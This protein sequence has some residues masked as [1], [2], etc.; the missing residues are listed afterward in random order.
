MSA[1][2]ESALRAR[3]LRFLLRERRAA[4]ADLHETWSLPLAARVDQGDAI[5][6]VRPVARDDEGR[7]LLAGRFDTARFRAG[8]R[9]RLGEVGGEPPWN[10]PELVLVGTDPIEGTLTLEVP[11]WDGD[12]QAVEELLASRRP[13]RLDRGDV[14]LS[15]LLRRALDRVFDADGALETAAR[16]LLD[17]RC[18]PA[19]DPAE[20]RT[21]ETSADRL[22]ALGVALDAPQREA[23]VRGW[24]R[25]P[26][27]LVQ[28]PPGTGKTWLVALLVA[29]QAWRGER[30]LVTAQTHLAVDN[31]LFALARLARRFGRPVP[32]VRVGP[33]PPLAR[34]AE[35][36][37]PVARSARRVSFPARG[38]LVVGATIYA[39]L[40]FAEQSAFGRV[41]F[42]EAAQIPLPHALCALLSADRWLLVGDDRQLGPVVV[43]RED[44]EAGR[45]IF[46]HLREVLEPT[47]LERTYR[48][49]E[50]L[51]AFPSRAF[52]G[53][54]LVP[55]ERA[56]A[57]RLRLSGRTE[58]P[59]LRAVIDEPAG[60]VLVTIA[61]RGCRTHARPERDAAVEIA[62][63][64]LARRGLPAAELAIVSPFRQQNQQIARA[65]RRTLGADAALP[66]VDTVERIQGQER[67]AVIVSLTCSDPEALSRDTRFLFSP[68]RLNVALTRARTRLIVLASPHL[69]DT[70]PRDHA[71]LRRVELFWRL[72][73]ELPG[74]DGTPRYGSP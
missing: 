69:L 61:H 36:G 63:E 9:L 73:D 37:I 54:R 35:A 59:F 20:R 19:D 27:H 62:A 6:D 1:S 40:P 3:L 10:C 67:E 29:A 12:P 14:D 23:F 53:G 70:L 50:A 15:D 58:D 2:G 26:V 45:S 8:D 65:L 38:G 46:A 55:A 24:S 57:R 5:A 34:W 49:N 32:M 66:L 31:V 43:S 51:C 72:F 11:R 28:G 17:R 7:I 18:A 33:K 30:V 21:A 39:S 64:L 47:L 68:N 22:G 48:L 4:L 25:A 16:A 44:D 60:P 52:Y 13:L 71:G 41:V 42:D 56:A 74:I